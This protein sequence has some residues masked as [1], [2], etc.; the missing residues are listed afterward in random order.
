ML[1]DIS[2]GAARKQAVP[3]PVEMATPFLD[4]SFNCEMVRTPVGT[5]EKEAS[6]PAESKR[7]LGPQLRVQQGSRD[8]RE[9]LYLEQS[10]VSALGQPRSRAFWARHPLLSLEVS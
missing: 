4:K 3:S 2:R 6:Q 8:S 1:P 10:S 5:L 7:G 9:N